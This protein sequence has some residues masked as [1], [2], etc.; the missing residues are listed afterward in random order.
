M[1]ETKT[2]IIDVVNLIFKRRWFIIRN[3]LIITVITST[4]T[5]IA[6]KT[7][8]SH[9]TILTPV[10]VGDGLDLSSVVSSLPFGGLGLGGSVAQV[11]LYTAI[12]NSRTIQESVITKFGLME[13]YQAEAMEF[14]LRQLQNQ[15]N[16]SLNDDG[17]I[18]LS[19]TAGT[20]F[21]PNEKDEEEA[22]NIASDI[23][24]Y[25]VFLLDERYKELKNEQ[26]VNNRA[27]IEKRYLQCLSELGDREI[28]FKEFQERHGLIALS[29]QTS[30]AIT[31]LN[32]IRT[33]MIAKE[34]EVG[35]L[36]SYMDESHQD[37]ERSRKEFLAFKRKYEELS[38]LSKNDTVFAG[39]KMDYLIPFSDLPELGLQYVRHY[40]QVKIQETLQEFLV[41]IYEQAKIQEARNNPTV[42]ILD[43]AVPSILRTS[44]KRTLTVLIMGFLSFIFSIVWINV[45]EFLS[46]LE[47]KDYEG[48]ILNQIKKGIS[49][50]FQRLKRPKR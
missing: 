35:L 45:E 39:K 43:E 29:E 23:A 13:R 20:K 26:A 32:E 21:R 28:R 1:K 27:F 17:T 18:T 38:G 24:N 49:K 4:F 33:N 42:Q 5:L 31:T 19:F 6:P 12:L 7:F 34:I 50:D 30:I 46:S 3:F 40:R 15:F 25:F 48:K 47:E 36:E 37:L 14:A 10:A 44:P 2:N 41:P 9:A 22:R 11:Q 8:T 16:V